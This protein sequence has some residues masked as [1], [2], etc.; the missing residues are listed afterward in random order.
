MK[1]NKPHNHQ[2]S[3]RKLRTASIGSE[4]NPAKFLDFDFHWQTGHIEKT[5][6]CWME[7][8]FAHFK[9]VRWNHLAF[10]CSVNHNHNGNHNGNHNVYSNSND[11]ELT[12]SSQAE[13]KEIISIM[14]IRIMLIS[15]S[16]EF[17]HISV[18]RTN[19]IFGFVLTSWQSKSFNILSNSGE[20]GKFECV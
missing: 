16:T 14:L 11:K 12:R 5:T 15:I 10:E 9:S 1:S 18:R 3:Q 17:M 20:L 7:T 8:I 19:R 2:I 13:F 6:R 4:S